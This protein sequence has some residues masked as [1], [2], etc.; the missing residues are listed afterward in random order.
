MPS[1]S[2]CRRCGWKTRKCPGRDLLCF[3]HCFVPDGVKTTFADMD[4]GVATARSMQQRQF[5][6]LPVSSGLSRI[7]AYGSIQQGLIKVIP[8]TIFLAYFHSVVLLAAL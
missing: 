4:A 1:H 2:F 6:Q 7:S 3:R 5:Q 8:L